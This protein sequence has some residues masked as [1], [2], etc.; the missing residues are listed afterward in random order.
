MEAG[1]IMTRITKF[2]RGAAV[3]ILSLA[4]TFQA[5]AAQRV[6]VERNGTYT[7]K[8]Q[9]AAYI[10]TFGKLPSNYITKAQARNLGW[11][12]SKGNLHKVAP[13][14][15]IGGDRFGNYEEILPVKRGRQYYECDI[16]YRGGRRNAKRIIFSSDGLIYYTED[17]YNTFEHLYGE[18][19]R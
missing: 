1:H 11:V 14:K 9:V 13:G 5:G 10:N 2:L 19:N 8:E 6:A 16:D 7:S 4:L 12:S 17:H 3:L 18:E 15:S